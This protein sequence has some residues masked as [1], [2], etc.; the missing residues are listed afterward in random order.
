[1]SETTEIPILP[2]KTQQSWR[3]WLDIHHLSTDQGIWLQIYKKG[4]TT[5]SI[6]YAEALDEALC[7]GWIDGQKKSYDNES[8]LQKFTPRRKRSMWSKVNIGHI[9]R[10]EQAGKMMTNGRLEVEKAKAD[11][12]WESAYHPASTAEVPHDLIERLSHH[13][14]AKAV[15]EKLSKSKRYSMIFRLHTAKKTETREKHLQKIVT[16][17]EQ[18]T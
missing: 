12:R 10:L 2:F 6:T 7:Y 14:K 8:W 13:P 5:T 16:D 15:F 3:Q 18:F 9:D 4:S 1:M 11:G 17:L